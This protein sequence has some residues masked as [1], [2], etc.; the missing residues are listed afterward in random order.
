M[1]VLSFK[2]LAYVVHVILGPN[3]G[4]YLGRGNQVLGEDE[5]L[6]IRKQKT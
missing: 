2:Q 3:R 5:D 1:Q 6:R 4:G